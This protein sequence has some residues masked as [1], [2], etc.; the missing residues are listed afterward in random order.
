[1]STFIIEH[2]LK[3]SER[4][5]E[6]WFYKAIWISLSVIQKNAKHMKSITEE[7]FIRRKFYNKKE[8]EKQNNILTDNEGMPGWP[9]R[10]NRWKL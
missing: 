5:L 4:N 6:L 9:E 1:M 7:V 3:I 2:I 8:N 10:K